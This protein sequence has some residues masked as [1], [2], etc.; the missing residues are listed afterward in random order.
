[1]SDFESLILPLDTR[2][3]RLLLSLVAIV[4]LSS[5]VFLV[6]LSRVGTLIAIEVDRAQDAYL[7]STGEHPRA[8]KNALQLGQCVRSDMKTSASLGILDAAW[9]PLA[10][11]KAEL[12]CQ[13]E[14]T[15]L[16]PFLPQPRRAQS[17]RAVP[18]MATAG[19]SPAYSEV[20]ARIS[21]R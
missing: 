11:S 10:R 18:A 7:R 16:A 3:A 8:F 17:V 14:L 19:A 13:A 9:A 21:E 20:A 4:M 2:R 15:P 5:L 6:L 1:M 12:R